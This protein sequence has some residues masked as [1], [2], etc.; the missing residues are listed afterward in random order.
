MIMSALKSRF[1]SRLDLPALSDVP[2]QPSYFN[3][4]ARLNSIYAKMQQCSTYLEIGLQFGYT[5]RDVLVPFKWGVDPELRFS[6][7]GLPEGVIVSDTTSDDFFESCP[8]NLRFDL[9]FI[10]GLHTWSQTYKDLVNALN[11]T[12]TGAVIV[13]D[14]VV[15]SDRFSALPSLEAATQGRIEH[16]VT[17][18]KWHGDV[19]KVLILLAE[20]HPE[21]AVRVVGTSDPGD[22][23]QAVVWRNGKL[24]NQENPHIIR[25]V[26]ADIDELNY[27]EV[28][29][30]ERWSGLFTSYPLDEVLDQIPG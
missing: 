30:S 13:I 28:F 26:P 22:N 29:A 6:K 2:A 21:L 23:P 8:D 25:S 20:C 24:N 5:F 14:D 3:S 16:G 9:V 1:Q 15:P 10:D 7:R 17:G 12:S 4:A 18:D 11:V 19:Y 27:D